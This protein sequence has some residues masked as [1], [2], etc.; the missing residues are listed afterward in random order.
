MYKRQAQASAW[1]NFATTILQTSTDDASLARAVDLL[2]RSVGQRTRIILEAG[3][4]REA[5]RQLGLSYANLG[6]ARIRADRNAE[7]RQFLE[8]AHK[9]AVD[10]RDAFLER[11]IRA[12]ANNN[13][14]IGLRVDDLPGGRAADPRSDA[15]CAICLD[16]LAGKVVYETACAHAFCKGCIQSWIAHA[17]GAPT[18]PTCKAHL[19]IPRGR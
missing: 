18:C 19:N 2:E 6:L 5:R 15:L 1:V 4:S 14:E 11:M 12:N 16:E 7:G 17:P 8:A 3:P 13:P 9:I 10:T